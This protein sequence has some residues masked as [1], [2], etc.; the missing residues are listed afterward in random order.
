MLQLSNLMLIRQVFNQRLD[1]ATN[2]VGIRVFG[3]D[4]AA[5]LCVGPVAVAFHYE[6]VGDLEGAFGVAGPF[7]NF[8]C[9]SGREVQGACAVGAVRV[10]GGQERG[11]QG[12]RGVALQVVC[13][14][15]V[16]VA[17]MGGDG[18]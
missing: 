12:L 14:R 15:A 8:P 1:I 2:S 9:F 18:G 6:A 13:V 3:A 4:D 11:V 17:W 10:F 5:V 16:E 7:G